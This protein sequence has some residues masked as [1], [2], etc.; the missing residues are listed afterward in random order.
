MGVASRRIVFT[1][2]GSLGDL[3]PYLAVAQELARRGH[4][5]LV[6]TLPTFRERVEA[7]G[8]EFHPIRAAM[9]AEPGPELIRRVFNGRKGIEYIVRELMLPALRT[10]YDD[11][12]A[13]ARKADLL[14][15]H[16]LTFA[17]PLV[18]ETRGLP[19][20]STQL[21]PTSLLSAT[22]PPLLPGLGV[23]RTL[24]LGP[25]GYRVVYRFADRQTRG[26]MR[27]Y[28]TLRAQLGLPDR[29]NVLF[30]GGHSPLRELA[31]F[32]PL[33]GRPQPDWP[34]ET[35]ATGFPFFEQPLSPDPALDAFLDAGEPP[36][37]FTLGSSAVMNP[38]DF[39]RVSAE[40]AR[41]LGRRALLLGVNFRTELQPAPTVRPQLSADVF[42]YGYGTYAQLFPR[43]AAI[44]H[45]GGVG[46][47]AEALRA[48]RPMLVVPYGA[49]Q[50]DNAA[51]VVRLGVGR[52]LTRGQY[53][54]ARVTLAL[55]HL[56]EKPQYA[57]RAE[58]V[59]TAIRAERG[60]EVAC[61]A[62]EAVLR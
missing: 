56:L 8:L 4:R 17:T 60:A 45:Q 6:A 28:D 31:L 18:A 22:D 5:P 39:F 3:H 46:T 29:G 32:S 52:T 2:V 16:P 20:I 44:V 50:P 9:M 13:A 7:A 27:P 57:H 53:R 40:A 47:T 55:Q 54:K 49:D 36:V 58:Q 15:T 26:W 41:D 61:D 34:A 33:F 51:R 30:A 38:G 12:C 37:I 1:A 10:A 35:I 42:A 59:G 14:I 24:G 19:W 21:A 25:A 48:G 23:L 43:A 62:I 11:T